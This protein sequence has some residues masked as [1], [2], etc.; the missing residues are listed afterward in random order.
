MKSTF[1]SD[2]YVT[3]ATVIPVLYLAL[4]LQGSAI[5]DLMAQWRTVNNQEWTFK[6]QAR[7]VGMAMFCIAAGGVVIFGLVGEYSALQ[8]LAYERVG[9]NTRADVY[10]PCIVLL[11]AVGVGPVW[12]FVRAFFGTLIDDQDAYL[13]KRAAGIDAKPI[14]DALPMS[15]RLGGLWD[16]V[17]ARRTHE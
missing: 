3:A 6:D 4:T 14:K 9:Q 11:V 1:N 10:E 8:A 15:C 13:T 2:F 5:R 12:W 16:R 17:R 7:A